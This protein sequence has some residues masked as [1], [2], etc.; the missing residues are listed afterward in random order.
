MLVVLATLSVQDTV[1][2]YQC[3]GGVSFATL[4]MLSFAGLRF[5]G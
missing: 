1:I 2:N 4:D 5:G 3:Q